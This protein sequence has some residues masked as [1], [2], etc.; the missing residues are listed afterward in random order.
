MKH[1]STQTIAGIEPLLN[2]I[3]RFSEL[4]EKKPGIYYYKSSAFLHFHEDGSQVYADI[5]LTPPNFKRLPVT[6]RAQQDELVNLI[7]EKLG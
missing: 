2:R 5:K 1:A 7:Q 3:R 6:T 4:K